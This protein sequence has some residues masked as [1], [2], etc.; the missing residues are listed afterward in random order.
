LDLTV[1]KRALITGITG[2][3][4]SYLAELLLDKGYEVFGLVRRAST[5]SFE[6]IDHLLHKVT[7]I[8]GDMSDQASLIDA[9]RQSQPD[10]VYNL[11]AQSFVAD[12]WKQSEYTGDVDALGVTRL[13]EAIRREKPDARFYQ[14]SSSE[15]FGKVRETPQTEN[16][17]FH[18]RS[19]YGVAK[20]Y[21]Y[22]ITLNYRE[23]FDI[24]ASNGILFNHESPRRGLEFVT[25]KITDGVARIKLGMESELRLGNLDASRDWGY[26]GDYVEMM[27]RM[28]Q[29]DEPDDFV[30]AS[31]ETHTVR[32]FCEIA[33]GRVGLEY[34]KYVVTDER[35]MRPAEVDLLH[36][37]S[38]KAREKLGWVPKVNFRDL[39]EMMVD[40]DMA[41]LSR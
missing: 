10:E 4:G 30:V 6:R 32:E 17:P 13:L 20:V 1:T 3:D 39:V 37:D 5:G 19:P 41:R 26:A 21:G 27:W 24:H 8:S 16:T 35:F 23:S 14:A 40:S 7:L 28:L 22:Y 29:Q 12:S 18:P 15:M 2:Q 9:M 33:F 34:E 38:S 36:G 11:A 31:G 25:R